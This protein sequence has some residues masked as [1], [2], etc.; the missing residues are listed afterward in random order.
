MPPL[1]FI[2]EDIKEKVGYPILFSE[3]KENKTGFCLPS[4]VSDNCQEIEDADPSS[5]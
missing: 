3:E 4:Q 5:V 1:G 2:P